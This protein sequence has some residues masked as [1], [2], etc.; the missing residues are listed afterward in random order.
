MKLKLRQQNQ[1][2]VQVTW[3]DVC[4]LNF[5]GYSGWDLSLVQA[6]HVPT[7]SLSFGLYPSKAAS[8][9]CLAWLISKGCPPL[10][11]V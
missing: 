11:C 8:R 3:I 1:I 5:S 4:F 6:W 10:F 7:M 9:A 2:R